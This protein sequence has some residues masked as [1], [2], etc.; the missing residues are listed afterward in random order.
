[1]PL[2]LEAPQNDIIPAEDPAISAPPEAHVQLPWRK[3]AAVLRVVVVSFVAF[4]VVG[5][6]LILGV[7]AVVRS[8]AGA[9]ELQLAGVPNL[10]RVDDQVWRG[11]APSVEGY[12][13]LA[14]AGI[15]TVVD[16]RAEE[17]LDVDADHLEDLGIEWVHIPIRDGQS[18]TQD[19]VDRFLAAVDDAGGPVYVHC[20][21]GVGRTGTMAAAYLTATG[22]ASGLS[23]LRRN[24]SVGPPSLEQMA[25]A[26]GL[27]GTRIE[28]PNAAVVAFSRVL[29]APRR[30]W[31]RY[32]I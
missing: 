25:F 9:D 6:L 27:E 14:D 5:N 4:L 3:M 20:G 22:Q 7:S 17:D 23:A 29:D 18:P 24:L 32:G 26:V 16:L 28:R 30:L 1:M 13:S 15:R 31:S 8:A 19:E 10:H 11:A 12:E 2:L 21:A